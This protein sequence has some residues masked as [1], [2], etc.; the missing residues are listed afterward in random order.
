MNIDSGY[1]AVHVLSISFR[2]PNKGNSPMGTMSFE[3]TLFRGTPFLDEPIFW[4]DP[5]GYFCDIISDIIGTSNQSTIRWPLR[6]QYA[7]KHPPTIT[8]P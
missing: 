8:D 6:H 2:M 7:A 5:G 3:T 4:T 1:T